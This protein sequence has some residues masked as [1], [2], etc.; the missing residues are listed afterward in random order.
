MDNPYVPVP[1]PMDEWVA[2]AAIERSLESLQLCHLA[3]ACIAA[4]EQ[5]FRDGWQAFTP[6]Q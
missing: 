2:N 4:W 1:L 3:G 6:V 5:C